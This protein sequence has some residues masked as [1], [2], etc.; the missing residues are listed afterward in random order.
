LLNPTL[1][2]DRNSFDVRI[3][4]RFSDRDNSFYRF[5]Y[6]DQPEIIPTPFESTGGDGGSWVTDI[7]H[8]SARSFVLS[9]THIFN[10]SFIN[11]F[12]FGYN[13]LFTRHLQFNSDRNLS[14]EYGFPGVPF[15]PVNG[16]LP[17][18]SFSDVASLGSPGWLP[19]VEYQNVFDY[20]DNLTLIRGKHSLKFGAEIR[21]EEFPILEPAFSR[22]SMSFGP[23]FTDNPAAPGTGGSGF[24]SFLLGVPDAGY[25][26][27]IHNIDYQRATF[28]FY[29]QDDYRV[30]PKLTLNLGLRYEIFTTIKEKYNAQATY[31]F[32]KEELLI[33][34]GR[35]AELTPTIASFIPMS[36]TASPGLISPELRDF[37]PRFGF[38]YNLAKRV[39]IRGGYGIFYGA[40]EIGPYSNPS[41]GYNPPFDKTE[42]YSAICGAPSAN[43]ALGPLDCAIPQLSVLSQGFPANAISDPNTPTLVGLDPNL[44]TPYVQ[45]WHVSTE[46]QLSPNTLFEVGYAG[47]KGTDLY[48]FVNGNQAAPTADPTIPYAVRRPNPSLGNT[49]TYLFASDVNSSYNGLETR[50]ERRYSGGLTFLVSYTWGHSLDEASNASTGTQ[51]NSGWRWATYPEWEYGNSDFDIRQRLAFS[52]TYELPFGHGKHFLSAVYGKAGEFVSGWQVS[53]ITTIQSGNW[54]TAL[55]WDG[56]FSNSDG[57]QRPDQ[58]AKPNGKPCVTG[59]FF[60]TCAFIDPALGSFGNAGRNTILGPGMQDWDFSVLKNFRL[61]E[62]V[63]LQFRAE[64]FNIAN[65]A[66][67]LFT[68]PGLN[69][70]NSSDA[71]GSPQFGYLTAARPARQIQFGL[72]LYY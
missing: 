26:N 45:Q 52:Y 58:I 46:Y 20:L 22:G 59:T 51:N 3:D 61:S 19:G 36:A 43:P 28:G 6:V 55:D 37:A 71:L 13:R 68:A 16:G 10:P 27:N 4:H 34:A 50:V 64:G 63:R 69:T 29:I 47:S 1:T 21:R 32:G 18:L 25:I 14:A 49:N 17:S 60:N 38:A 9:E 44:R 35:Q 2:Q 54:F 66:N 23:Q 31:D 56:N 5:S 65:H 62:R 30:L 12:R 72:K 7:E 57:S 24:A 67:L 15:G 11:E 40:D 70:G 42:S 53:G 8:N 48:S 39:V 33:P 41:P